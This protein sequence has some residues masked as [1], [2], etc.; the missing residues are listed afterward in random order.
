MKKQIKYCENPDCRD[1]IV[2]YRSS[3]RKYCSDY[4]RNYHGHK[5]RTAENSEIIIFQKGYFENYKLLKLF[6]DKNIFIEDLVLYEKFGFNTKY[7][8]TPVYYKINGKKTCC[9]E[10]KD[11]LFGLDPNDQTKII[12]YKKTE[13]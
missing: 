8:P 11:I 4:C 12:I 5:R 6:R 9:F 1:E 13:N 10:I 2:N 3:K 7:F